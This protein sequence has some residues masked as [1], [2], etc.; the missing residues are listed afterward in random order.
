MKWETV[1]INKP[2]R[3]TEAFASVGRSAITL[4]G[5]ACQLIA[6]FPKYT[7]GHIMRGQIDGKKVLGI[8]LLENEEKNSL[9]IIKRKVHNE[10]VAYSGSLNSKPV[11]EELFGIIGTQNKVTNYSITLD[12]EE[13]NVLIIH[14]EN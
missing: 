2:K 11:M 5:G 3:K 6:D 8:R 7:F 4:S 9:R 14:L 10:V 13:R 1:E 12:P